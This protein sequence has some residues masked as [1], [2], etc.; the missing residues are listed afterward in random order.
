MTSRMPELEQS[1]HGVFRDWNSN[2]SGA[3]VSER[4]FYAAV[5]LSFAAGVLIGW[6]ANRQRRKYLDWKKKRLHDKLVETQKKLDL[7]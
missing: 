7:S 1:V 2:Q 3:E 4:G 5:F 6:Q